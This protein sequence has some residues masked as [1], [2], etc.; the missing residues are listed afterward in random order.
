[1]PDL[2]VST[3]LLKS[4]SFW[5]TVILAF[6]FSVSILLLI[7]SFFE[8]VRFRRKV[9]KIK[10]NLFFVLSVVSML[11]SVI[12]FFAMFRQ[13]FTSFLPLLFVWVLWGFASGFAHNFFLDKSKKRSSKEKQAKS[14]LE[15]EEG[16]EENLGIGS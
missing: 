14:I 6:L 10:R 1:M 8:S 4:L 11:F 5:Q 3:L 15:N 16:Y 12:V 9:R 7:I 2:I 13:H